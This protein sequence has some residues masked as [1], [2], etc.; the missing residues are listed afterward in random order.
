M[1]KKK[2]PETRVRTMPLYRAKEWVMVSKETAQGTMSFD[3][4]HL[5]T[6]G[7]IEPIAYDK[8]GYMMSPELAPGFSA[9]YEAN[10]GRGYLFKQN[11][12][13]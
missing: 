10:P 12:I 9:Y 3:W 2:Q 4:E 1:A 8:S 5:K 13:A 6:L 7:T 11:W